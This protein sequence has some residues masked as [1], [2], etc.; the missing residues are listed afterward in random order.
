MGKPL[1]IDE[2]IGACKSVKISLV[3]DDQE[4]K[5]YYLLHLN[6][7]ELHVCDGFSQDTRN[8]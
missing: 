2:I 5:R 7:I 8:D 6:I 1:L 4:T 3:L